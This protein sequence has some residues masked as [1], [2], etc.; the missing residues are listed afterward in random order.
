MDFF[1]LNTTPSV[2]YCNMIENR[3]RNCVLNKVT[4]VYLETLNISCAVGFRT[5]EAALKKGKNIH[6]I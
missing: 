6:Q 3:V 2:I 1:F 5:L 4:S